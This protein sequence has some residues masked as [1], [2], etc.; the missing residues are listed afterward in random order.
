MSISVRPA[1]AA[2]VAVMS[3]VLIASITELCEADH[4][5]DPGRI[6]TWT[7]NKTPEGVRAMLAHPELQMLVAERNGVVAAVGAVRGSEIARNYVAPEHRFAGVSKALLAALEAALRESGVR[8]AELTSTRTARSFYRAAG[9]SD[10]A[11]MV[12]CQVGEGIRMHKVL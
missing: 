9:W 6:A 2:D 5:G 1:R 10:E 11:A 4:G 7:A 3:R 12:P 8:R